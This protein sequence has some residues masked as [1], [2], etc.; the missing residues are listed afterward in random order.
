MVDGE[1]LARND[2]PPATRQPYE[3]GLRV[4]EWLFSR[5]LSDDHAALAAGLGLC[6]F[7]VGVKAYLLTWYRLG[8]IQPVPAGSRLFTS[9]LFGY[10][11]FTAALFAGSCF[12]FLLVSRLL[13]FPA[14]LRI[15][16]IACAYA[17]AVGISVISTRLQQLYGQPLT[18]AMMNWFRDLGA[19]RDSLTGSIDI[20]FMAILTLGLLS[21]PIAYA[22]GR[23][24]LARLRLRR[25]SLWAFA[26][27]LPLAAAIASGLAFRGEEMAHGIKQDSVLIFVRWNW[28]E[29]SK[30]DFRRELEQARAAGELSGTLDPDLRSI[31]YPGQRDSGAFARANLPAGANLLLIILESTPA[32]ALDSATTPNLLALA[33]RATVLGHHYSTAPVTF[34]AQYAILFSQLFRHT[35]FDY[36]S[37]Y[38][39]PPRDVSLLDVARAAGMRT[40][41]FL[42][43]YSDVFDE[44]WLYEGKT[45]VFSGAENTLAG[46]QPGWSWGAPGEKTVDELLVWLRKNQNQRFFAIYNLVNPHHPYTSPDQTFPGRGKDIAYRNAL[47]Y[48]DGAVGRL[49]TGLDSLDLTSKTIVVA[50]ADHG[51]E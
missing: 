51:E 14:P 20:S 28:T 13:K 22:A 11:A 5:D 31:V 7:L 19:L 6:V 4:A 24:L 1:A 27:G 39:C 48:A 46:L 18:L 38:Q 40:A 34:D 42:S 8:G 3:P 50:V 26:L 45:E 29:P 47:H 9:L 25:W 43:S 16:F 33:S 36:R 32:D 41:V 37:L 23:P 10:D 2:S 21:L 35:A 49:L 12:C 17:G 44:R 30:A 15:G